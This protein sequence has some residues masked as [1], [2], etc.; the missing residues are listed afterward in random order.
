MRPDSKSPLRRHLGACSLIA[1]LAAAGPASAEDI[2][3]AEALFNRG[4]S[5]MEAGRYETGCKAIAESQHLD[6]R[7]G[8]LFTLATCE[9]RWGR[10][11][12]AFTRYGDYLALYDSLPADRKAAQ[13]ERPNVARA[14]REKL[15]P[16]VPRLTL[17]L[18][19]G[20]PAGTVVKRDGEEVPALALG[21]ELP[22]D[23]G[24]HTVSIQPPGGAIREQRITIAKGEKEALTLS[25]EVRIAPALA[26]V[27]PPP[28]RKPPVTK[29]PARS[30][31]GPTLAF[32]AGAAGLGAGLGLGIAVLGKRSELDRVCP[33]HDCPAS[34]RGRLET[35]KALSYGSTAGF[36]L[37]GLGLTTGVVTLLLPA[38]AGEKSR[39][40][41]VRLGAGYAG[42]EGVF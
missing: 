39:S 1:C 19:P 11:A 32:G 21:I 20:A 37:A 31:L 27:T 12:T 3:S 2:A 35:A 41:G 15:A 29:R 10:L 25:I 34:E 14:E 16:D 9:A 33:N 6:P 7:A 38:R 23:P 18:P 28:A 26:V 8:T 36:V 5:D 42:I 30:Y 13:G 22:V 17:S 4:L 24:E 40:A